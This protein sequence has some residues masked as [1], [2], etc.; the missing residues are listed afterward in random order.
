[1]KKTSIFILTLLFIGG[2]WSA[3]LPN[4]QTHVER[5]NAKDL[6]NLVNYSERYLSVDDI[7]RSLMQQDQ[8]L[9]LI[10]VRKP[11]QYKEFTLP[12]AI[13]IP[14]DSLFLQKNLQLLSGA[15]V[16]TIVFFSNGSSLA[17]KAWLIATAAGY[18]NL[19][20]LKGGLNAW[21]NELLQPKRP[22][23]W[24]TKEEFDK[25]NFRLAAARYFTGA[26]GTDDAT[27]SKPVVKVQVP[28]KKKQ[29]GG[30]CE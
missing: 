7:A 2:L 5:V 4:V 28:V 14:I 21:F 3:F 13:N 15:D 19:Y 22:A 27:S 25:Y 18:N 29:V 11:E 23:D 16:Y 9:L 6:L 1:M 26:S 24:A 8:F 10:D 17:D 20:V 12:G 30:G